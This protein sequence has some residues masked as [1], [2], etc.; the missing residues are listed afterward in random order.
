[1]TVSFKIY[2]KTL[3][4]Y[5]RDEGYIRVAENAL[6]KLKKIPNLDQA[7]ENKLQFREAQLAWL[8]GDQMIAQQLLRK[9][10]NSDHIDPRL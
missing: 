8:N 1:M 6:I 9:L 10:C 2:V 4:D 3:L 5:A 7:V